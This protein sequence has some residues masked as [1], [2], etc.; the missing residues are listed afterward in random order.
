MTPASLSATQPV[1]LAALESV[2]AGA[3]ERARR[4]GADEAE[5]CVESTR[6]FGVRVNAG[7]I[8]S[9]K[10]SAT[11]GLGLRVVV[12]GAVGFVSTTDLA[13]SALDDV[14]RKA[15]AFARLSTPE[16]ANALP[17]P[18]EASGEPP[19]D[20]GLFDPELI[21]LPA[22]RKIEMA[23]TLERIA[24]GYD[25]RIRRTD[26]VRVA[27][28]DGSVAVVNSAGVSC[29]W[30]GTSASLS[31]VALAEDR[32][33]KQQSGGYGLG[34][35]RLRDLPALEEVANEAGRRAVARIGARTVPAARV[36]VILHPDIAAAWLS[37]IYDA[38]TGE[39]VIRKASWLTEK[40]GET[41]ASPLVKLVDDGRMRGGLGSAP[42]DGEGIPTRRNVLIENGRCAMFAYDAYHARRAGTR[43]TGN[44][45]RS[46]DSLPGIGY[47]NLF[48]EPGD[49]SPEA[50]IARVDHGFYMDDQG[51]FGYNEVTGDY[52]YQAQGYWIEK[53]EKAFP[54]EGVTVAST[55]L[56][57][58]GQIAAVG[59][60]LR[61]EDHVSSP[62]L[63][64]SE[65]T[66]SGAGE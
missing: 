62:T 18:S 4:A 10:H 53:G 36:P 40:L 35:R 47:H 58:L 64:I 48:L 22:E 12:A 27:T 11:Y 66:V 39:A 1:P 38:F 19:G 2:A 60:D 57:M 46:Y 37:E 54:V 33:G 34:K 31:V 28:R 15:V 51:S 6:G 21:E 8:E 20:L 32:D 17:T 24:L 7:Q 25:P 5:A 13:A 43:S 29:A 52:S 3:V 41:I 55:S 56:A 30:S 44:A 59:N 42:F 23:L 14:A 45:V 63:L 9:L 61:F 49:D 16:P 26:G 65:M 50:I